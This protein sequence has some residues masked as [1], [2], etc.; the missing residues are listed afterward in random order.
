VSLASGNDTDPTDLD[1]EYDSELD[2]DMD[3]R[4]ED[5]VDTLDGV[6]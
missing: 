1:G 4:K 2:P 3:I 6:D 5:D